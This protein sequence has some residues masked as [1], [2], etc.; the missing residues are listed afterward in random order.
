[1]KSVRDHAIAVLLGANSCP[2]H[3]SGI[4]VDDID[5]VIGAFEGCTCE[6]NMKP[7]CHDYDDREGIALLKLKDGRV[8]FVHEAEDTT[9]H[10]C[11]CC[12]SV[13]FYESV[14]EAKRIGLTEQQRK[15]IHWN[16]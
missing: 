14:E 11:Q 8:V 2:E 16:S 4:G 6:W 3:H 13:E 5:E 10:G 15:V 9:G 1:M 7:P 12:A